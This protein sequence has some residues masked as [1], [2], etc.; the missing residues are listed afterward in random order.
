MRGG[1]T[2]VDDPRGLAGRGSRR[3]RAIRRPPPPPAGGSGKYFRI[4]YPG[5][6]EPNQLQTPV[7]YLLW[8]PDGA[9]QLRGLIVHQHGAGTT[10]SIEGSTGAYDLHWQA[11]AKKWDCALWSSSYHVRNEAV[12]LTPGGS[13]HW[14]DPRRGSEKTFLKAIDDFAAKSGHAELSKVPWILWGHSG[15]GIW[16]DV[17]ATLHPDRVAAVW[18]RSG[19]AVMFRARKEFPQ[20]TVTEAAFKVPEM[21]NPGAKETGPYTGALATFKQYRAKGAPVGF[22]PDPRT[23]H[24]CGDSRY[25]AIPYLDACMAMRLPDKGSKDQ[26]LKPVDMSKGWLASLVEKNPQNAAAVP[27][28]EYKGNPNEAVWLPNEAVAKAWVEY[29]KTGAVGDTTPPPVPFDVKTIDRGGAPGT[30]GQGTEVTWIAMAD[31]ESGIKQF[32]ILR[33]G[34]ELATVGPDRGQFGRPI[35]QGMTYHDTP[36]WPLKETK[37]LDSTAKAGEKHTYTVITVN[38]V[39]LKSA[40]SDPATMPAVAQSPPAPA[41]ASASS[42]FSVVAPKAQPV[43]SS[44]SGGIE[45]LKDIVIGTGGG[46]ALH[47]DIAR[48]KTPPAGLMPAVLWIHGGGWTSGSHHDFQ[49][50]VQ[51]ANHGYLVLSV[52]YRFVNEAI[53]PA[54]I[55]DCKLAVRWLRANAAKH[56]VNPDRIGCWGTSAGGHLAALMG[57]TGDKPDL[58]GKGGSAGFS[59]AVQA[60]VDFCGPTDFKGRSD[61]TRKMAGGTYEEKTNV[62]KQMSPLENVNPKAC[63][64]L[65]VNGEKDTTVPVFH[66]ELMTEALKKVNVPVELII[67]KNAGHGYVFVAP[68]GGPPAQPSPAEVDAAVLKFLDANLKSSQPRP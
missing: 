56:Q 44:T 1:G 68:R 40:P 37:Y 12:D 41:A 43:K 34:K 33:D 42:S 38:S 57:V 2:V 49:Q 53:W 16:S 28:A 23:G 54:Q 36:V 11:L 48:P 59:S 39:G 32:I 63:P 60:V 15:G 9:K 65:I 10:A 62:F 58:E 6:T 31:F 24:E 5:S 46:R 18:M 22:A 19:A 52:E 35:F 29:V 26:T 20:P 7:S 4:D 64:F 30:P 14:F 3:Q 8:I 66:A 45:I 27:A 61:A 51:L 55:E 50:T 25:L 47:A 17:M 67:V 13:E 21:G